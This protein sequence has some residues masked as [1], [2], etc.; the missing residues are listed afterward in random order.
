LNVWILNILFSL[1]AGVNAL[2]WG[3]CIKDVEVPVLSIGFLL[4]LILN[5]FFILAMFTAFAA[6]L[7][8][9][10]VVQDMGVFRA[11]F[12]LTMSSVTIILVSV[13]VLGE[14]ITLWH[15]FGIVLIMLGVYIL[16]VGR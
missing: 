6:S 2:F 7:V 14:K 3:L 5:K 9:Y 15:C 1:L 8:R 16:G 4:K 12:F 11:N 13:L 10:A